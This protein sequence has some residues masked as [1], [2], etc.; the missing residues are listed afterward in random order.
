MGETVN[1]SVDFMDRETQPP[2]C[3]LSSLLI[4]PPSTIG[5]IRTGYFSSKTRFLACLPLIV[6]ANQ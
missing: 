4:P 5:R 1:W 3:N 6:D 2:K